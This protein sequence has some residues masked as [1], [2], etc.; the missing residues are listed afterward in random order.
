[1]LNAL[2]DVTKDALRENE[3]I[4]SFVLDDLSIAELNL[5][6][7]LLDLSEINVKIKNSSQEYQNVQEIKMLMQPL[8]QNGMLSLGDL[9]RI[10]FA[11]SASEILNYAEQAQEYTE[12]KQ[13]EQMQAQEEML[14]RQE[15]LQMQLAQMQIDAELEKEDRRGEL[16]IL[17]ATIESSRFK[18]QKDVDA[19]Q[20][21]DDITKET[22]KQQFEAEKQ[23]KDQLSNER[24]NDK[25]RKLERDKM[26]IDKELAEKKIAVDKI[27]ARKTTPKK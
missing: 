18:Q 10:S 26:M 12:K 7:E 2:V 16:E 6:W 22:I 5:N 15:Q 4:A 19:N 13:Q 17:K 20:V 14:A 1:L 9:I 3:D 21:N 27:K 23:R 8:V 24:E 25:N 11:K